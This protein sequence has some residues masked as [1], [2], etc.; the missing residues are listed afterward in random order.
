MREEE[1]TILRGRNHTTTQRETHTLRQTHSLTALVLGVWFA[2]EGC[3][4]EAPGSVSVLETVTMLFPA[5]RSL[6]VPLSARG[7]TLHFSKAQTTQFWHLYSVQSTSHG[8]PGLATNIHNQINIYT[9]W[10]A[11]PLSSFSFIFLLPLFIFFLPI[12]MHFTSSFSTL[13]NLFR[14]LSLPLF[15]MSSFLSSP[16]SLFVLQTFWSRLNWHEE[17]PNTFWFVFICCLH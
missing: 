7:P 12:L 11:S 15:S 8:Q 16:R 3:V 17:K 6:A 9:V 4:K 10:L 5:S 14:P 2:A 13:A 1:E